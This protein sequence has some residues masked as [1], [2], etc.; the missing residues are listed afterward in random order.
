VIW[1]FI[2]TGFNTGNYNMAF[3]LELAHSCKPDES[4]LRLYRWKPYCISLGVNQSFDN[5]NLEKLKEDN[6]D[7]VKRPTGG[8][9]VLHSEELTYS[10]VMPI[11][12]QSS[13][14][15]IYRD[16][17]MALAAGLNLYDRNLTNIELENVQPDFKNFYKQENSFSCFSVSAKSELKFNGKKLVGSAQRKFGNV[18]L[19]HGSILCGN[20]HKKISDYVNHSIPDQQFDFS[21]DELT[22]DLNSIT[23]KKIN[24]DILAKSIFKGFQLFY[25]AAFE[26]I[27]NLEEPVPDNI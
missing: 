9:A 16:I 17:N 13:P 19:Q 3:D 22:V 18:I 14:R 11:T 4:Y 7:I 25:E 27:N 20:Y 12:R 1:R 24:Y 26:E 6:I 5:F 2:N 23:N 15:N 10:V 8:R 21:P